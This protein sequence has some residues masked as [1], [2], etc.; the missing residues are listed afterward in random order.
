MET[1]STFRH[2]TPFR[3]FGADAK[4]LT[5]YAFSATSFPKNASCT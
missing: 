1:A 2:I 3:R 5:P 4:R